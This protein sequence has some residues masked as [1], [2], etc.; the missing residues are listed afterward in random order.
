[1]ASEGSK[2]VEALGSD[3][4]RQITAVFGAALTGDFLYPQLVCGGT[5]PT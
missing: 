1:M 2:R 5:I 4:K 3:D